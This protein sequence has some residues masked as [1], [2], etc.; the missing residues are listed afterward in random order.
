M[1]R[2]SGINQAQIIEAPLREFEPREH[3]L[4]LAGG[5]TNCPDWQQDLIK[6]LEN[7]PNL[8]ILNPRRK[9]FPIHDPNVA[10]EQ[11]KWEY[12]FLKNANMIAVWFSRGSLNP[13]VLYEL[14]MWVNSRP[15]IPAFVG[16]DPE[17]SRAQ[18]VIIQ[19]KLARPEINTTSTLDALAD[20]IKDFLGK[21]TR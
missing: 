12:D 2:L 5:I 1:E 11:I 14:G 6:N 7:T 8:T 15:E 20:Q 18:D 4:F 21:K 13:I 3:M 19:T 10:R 9:E 16:I 17:Y